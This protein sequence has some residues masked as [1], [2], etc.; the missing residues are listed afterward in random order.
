MLRQM[1]ADF[2][3]ELLKLVEHIGLEGIIYLG[4][5][6][7]DDFGFVQLA[8]TGIGQRADIFRCQIDMS[9]GCPAFQAL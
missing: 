8:G 3:E 7:V 1:G 5:A 6:A 2:V 9:A 4:R